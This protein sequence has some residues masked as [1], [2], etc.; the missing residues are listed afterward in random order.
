MIVC[1]P[2]MGSSGVIIMETPGSRVPKTRVLL[3]KMT[4]VI[5]P[6][7]VFFV[8]TRWYTGTCILKRAGNEEVASSSSSPL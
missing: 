7:Q 6:R 1:D 8:G 3:A 4:V 5:I 2:L